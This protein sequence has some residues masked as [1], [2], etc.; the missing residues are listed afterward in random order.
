MHPL[1]LRVI[2]L[3]KKF[4]ASHT[5][6]LETFRMEFLLP[7]IDRFFRDDLPKIMGAETL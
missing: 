5:G 6:G 1:G 7:K 4:C 3:E 2:F